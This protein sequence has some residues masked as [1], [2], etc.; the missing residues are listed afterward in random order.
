MATLSRAPRSSQMISDEPPPMSNS[1]MDSAS[2]SASSLQ[3]AT[4]SV[5]SVSRSTISS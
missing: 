4:A 5:A 1:R 3:P 2:R